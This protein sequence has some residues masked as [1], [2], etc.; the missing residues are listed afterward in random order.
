MD[1]STQNIAALHKTIVGHSGERNG[2]KVKKPHLNS[3]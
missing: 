2:R 1:D 3:N